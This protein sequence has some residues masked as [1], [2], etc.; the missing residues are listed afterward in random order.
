[1][2]TPH[3]LSWVA[4]PIDPAARELYVM[5]SEPEPSGSGRIIAVLHRLTPP[6]GAEHVYTFGPGY[7]TR[8][9][10]GGIAYLGERKVVAAWINAQYLVRVDDAMIREDRDLPGFQCG[11]AEDSDGFSSI[12]YVPNVGVV[13]G[14]FCG[15]LYTGDGDGAFTLLTQ[16]TFGNYAVRRIAPYRGGFAYVAENWQIGQYSPLQGR[17]EDRFP[18]ADGFRD[19]ADRLVG[20]G[21]DLVA[22]GEPGEGESENVI[23]WLIRN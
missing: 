8:G 3:D 16:F 15:A 18:P 23:R 1:V 6:D 21:G 14:S 13:A 12:T 20:V 19:R 9:G 10:H 2:L 5:H 11:A 22:G 7:R 4:G 17:C